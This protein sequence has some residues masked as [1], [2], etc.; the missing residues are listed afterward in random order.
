[1]FNVGIARLLELRERGEALGWRRAR[2]GGAPVQ[3]P[4]TRTGATGP[5][6]HRAGSPQLPAPLRSL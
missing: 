1:M 6:R 3:H 5:G 2:L 4:G